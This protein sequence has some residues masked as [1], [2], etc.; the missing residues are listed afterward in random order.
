MKC[1]PGLR[2]LQRYGIRTVSSQPSSPSLSSIIPRSSHANSFKNPIHNPDRATSL[3]L[4]LLLLLCSSLCFHFHPP[5]SCPSFQA[6]MQLFFLEA[7]LDF[8]LA[9]RNAP[10]YTTPLCLLG[11]KTVSFQAMSSRATLENNR[12]G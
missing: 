1:Q 8:F 3:S 2:S 6:Q 10:S 5:Q 9:R 7:S 12:L 11:K 4:L